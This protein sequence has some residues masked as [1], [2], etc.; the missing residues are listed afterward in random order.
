MLAELPR[1][2]LLDWGDYGFLRTFSLYLAFLL[3]GAIASHITVRLRAQAH[4]H[5]HVEKLAASVFNTVSEGILVTDG[6]NRITAVNPGFS[7]ITGYSETEVLGRNPKILS[8][9]RQDSDF[10]QEVFSNLLEKLAAD[11]ESPLL[12]KVRIED[13]D[14]LEEELSETARDTQAI[15]MAQE[16]RSERRFG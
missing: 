5:R 10:Y 8:S 1:R 14:D 15:N 16:L 7:R 4:R 3:A 2:P 13:F 6:R 9:G 11:E 12:E